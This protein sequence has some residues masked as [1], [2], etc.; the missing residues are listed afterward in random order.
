MLTF[1]QLEAFKAV[2]DVGSVVRAADVIGLS[3]PAV[4]RL[5]S[6]LEANIG[7][8]LFDRRRGRL[9][10]RDEAR[11]LYLEVERSFIGLDRI[12]ESAERIGRRQTSHIRVAALPGL[13]AGPLAAVVAR[14]VDKHTDV[15]LSLEA[16]TRPQ[17]LDGIADGLHDIG[18]ASMPIEIPDVGVQ[19]LL[20]IEFLCLVPADHPLSHRDVIRPRDL[21]GV[22][23]I[24]GAD[25]TPLRQKVGQIFT[26]AGIRPDICVEVTT[27]QSGIAL[28]ARGLGVC[29]GW[30]LTFD[31][32]TEDRVRVIPFRPK[33]SAE[34]AV[35]YKAD[36]PPEG[37]VAEFVDAYAAA[38]RAWPSITP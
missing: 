19:T 10:P 13:T 4:S 20:S 21:D 24:M 6:D 16:R 37:I 23:C 11:E 9:T 32:L 34:V 33:I 1:R 5:L 14:F 29:L 25:R 8:R 38:A 17:I 7:Y 36:R 22:R 27:A 31:H 18:L 12:G 3:Q 2:I 28:A 30:G 35:I 15:F 26:E